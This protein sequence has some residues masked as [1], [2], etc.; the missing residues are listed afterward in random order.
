MVNQISE[1]PT[2]SKLVEKK[3]Y[4]LISHI[5]LSD[6]AMEQ[7]KVHI[8]PKLVELKEEKIFMKCFPLL[9]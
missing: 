6:E 8:L 4:C 3:L 5:E 1:H 9:R 2:S 7:I